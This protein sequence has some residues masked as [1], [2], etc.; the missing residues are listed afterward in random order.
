MRSSDQHGI[1]LAE[2]V[3]KPHR[4]WRACWGKLHCFASSSRK[5]D[6]HHPHLLPAP[7]AANSSCNGDLQISGPM[8]ASSSISPLVYA[9]P[10]SPA[11]L[12]Y[13]DNVPSPAALLTLFPLKCVD[14]LCSNATP[15][16]DSSFRSLD[17]VLVT[18][19]LHSTLTT[20]PTTPLSTAPFTP[21]PELA[22][23]TTPSSPEVPFAELVASSLSVKCGEHVSEQTT[24]I[25]ASINPVSAELGYQ[26][27]LGNPVTISEAFSTEVPSPLPE[28]V[29]FL[30]GGTDTT[31]ITSLLERASPFGFNQATSADVYGHCSPELIYQ[32]VLDPKE[33]QYVQA[34]NALLKLQSDAFHRERHLQSYDIT[35]AVEHGYDAITKKQQAVQVLNDGDQG[36]HIEISD[37]SSANCAQIF[38]DSCYKNN[39][40]GPGFFFTRNML[41]RNVVLQPNDWK[42]GPEFNTNQPSVSNIG[43]YAERHQDGTQSAQNCST[44]EVL[45]FE[46]KA[47]SE[48][49]HDTEKKL[50][51]VEGKKNTLD[52]REKSASKY[53]NG[54]S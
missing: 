30:H 7:S 1:Q 17:S 26:V 43:R 50:S 35:L 32:H 25:E 46:C 52:V 41:E 31:S 9:P 39:E 42:R 11:S 28:R 37:L 54:Y 16:G 3:H 48:A 49:L 51:S 47:L 40:D 23:L 18:P 22:H 5:R 27:C 10:S 53:M 44:C 6:R 21:P 13:T 14:D 19:P 2:A 38:K 34:E 20:E 15:R 8:P 36:R 24:T 4:G 12:S 45:T 29:P 33:R